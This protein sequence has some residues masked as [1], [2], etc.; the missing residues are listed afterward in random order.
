[1]RSDAAARYR[2]LAPDNL[3]GVEV[4]QNIPG[5]FGKQVGVEEI[6]ATGSLGVFFGG[7]PNVTRTLLPF[8]LIAAWDGVY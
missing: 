8:S 4:E 1:M 2:N 5:R 6:S 3:R 7:E